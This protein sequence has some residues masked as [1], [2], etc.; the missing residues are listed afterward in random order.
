MYLYSF[1]DSVIYSWL[2]H[3]PYGTLVP[4]RKIER[5]KPSTLRM[6][7]PNHCTTR[8]FPRIPVFKPL[9]KTI[10]VEESPED[11]VYLMGCVHLKCLTSYFKGYLCT[12]L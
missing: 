2:C 1:K 12:I 6:W 10:L 8:E 9:F 4:R 5:K 7:S 11:L 3:A